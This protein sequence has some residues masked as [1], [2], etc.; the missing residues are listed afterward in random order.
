[1]QANWDEKYLTE[2]GYFSPVNRGSKVSH[3]DEMSHTSY[4]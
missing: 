3:S 2:V 1:M 4:K